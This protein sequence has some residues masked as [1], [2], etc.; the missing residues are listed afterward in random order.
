MVGTLI[1]DWA[2]IPF[3]FWIVLTLIFVLKP[4]FSLTFQ[5]LCNRLLGTVFGILLVALLF[6]DLSDPR[7]L[8]WLAMA[9]MA[10]AMVF[11]RFHY[12]VA[13]F[14]ITVFALFLS[15]LSPPIAADPLLM[16]LLCTLIGT[17]LAFGVAF[18]LGQQSEEKQF[19]Q[20]SAL[21]IAALQ[22]YFQRLIPALVD[23]KPL[24]HQEL[25]AARC[26]YRLKIATLQADLERLL[27]D[28]R[29]PLAA[30]EP[31]ITLT[32]Y[33]SRLGRGFRA[34]VSHLEKRSASESPPP[35]EV[36]AEQVNVSLQT[37]QTALANQ[38]PPHPLPPLG[39]TLGELQAFHRVHQAQRLTE[40][41]QQQH[42]TRTYFY[43][44]DFNLVVAEC[45]EICQRL[46][47][48]HQA[49]ARLAAAKG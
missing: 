44:Q 23:R 45:R 26:H 38:S 3:G 37:L 36:F 11:L 25:E 22:D 21:A 18:G 39:Q 28:P 33:I 29:T 15:A 34:L 27:N 5:R 32:H 42:Q 49:I 16:R 10:I 14:F 6:P 17:G 1:A 8:A 2:Q 41:H 43:L 40:I 4:D 35:L 9:S 46:D 47:S 48:L 31:A 13:V 20:A 24:S 19:A 30:Q 12:S 7:L